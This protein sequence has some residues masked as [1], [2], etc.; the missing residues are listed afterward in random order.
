[1][2]PRPG[3]ARRRRGTWPSRTGVVAEVG[4]GLAGGR[5]R[6]RR[7]RPPGDARRGRRPRAPRTTPAAPTGRAST[8]APRALAAG[9]ATCAV[10][11]PLN[12]LPP[13][14][15][16]ASFDAKVAAARGRARVDFA[17][18]GG[19]VPGDLDRMDELAERGVVGFKAF[20]CPSGVAE[21]P[22][23]DADVLGRG[24]E[25]AAALGLPVAVHAEDPR[26]HGPPGRAGAWPRAGAAMRDWAGVAAGA[27]RARR[28]SSARSRLARETGCALHVVHVSSAAAVDLVA[29]A[30]ARGVDATCE[31][32]PHYLVLDED[33]A[34]RLGAVAKCAPPLRSAAERDGPVGSACAP[35]TVDLVASDHSP[36]PP[37]LKRGGRH[38]RGVGRDLGRAD[39]PAAAADPR[40]GPRASRSSAR[41]TCSAPAPARALRPGRQGRPA[42][43]RRR[44]H[45]HRADSA[46]P[47]TCGPRTWSTATAS[48]PSSAGG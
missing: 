9:G 19:L 18:W 11:M 33:D 25:R 42:A 12:S 43:R 29:E 24:M 21:F 30:R 17:L 27:R 47:G 20:M 39:D 44:R 48:R 37:E 32:C 26:D 8:P 16:A 5:A 13:T 46:S 4:P 45:R 10:D 2:S 36:G 40:P 14:L 3:G 34:E 22:A 28:P 6:D 35:A 23:A 38:V 1:M 15:D 31:T 41:R 7:P